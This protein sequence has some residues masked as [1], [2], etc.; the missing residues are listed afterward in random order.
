[1]AVGNV[2]SGLDISSLVQQLVSAE[3]APATARL[4]RDG[5]R[6][7]AEISA[8]GTLRSSFSNL[9]TALASVASAQT[10]PARK[11]IVPEGAG[12]SATSTAAASPARHQIEVRALATAHKLSSTAF[13]NADATVG[14]G[15]LTIT[16][17]T[18]T[19]TVD[20]SA[21]GNSLSALRDA[22]N[23]KAAGKGVA[24]TI[25]TADDGAHLM[26]T[27]LDTGTAH[28]I[29]VAA[30]GGDGGLA[31]FVYD[32]D[33]TRAMNQVAA[34]NDAVVAIDGMTRTSSSN[35]L[36]NA[37]SGVSL[38][39]TKAEPGT[40]RDLR[41]EADTGAQRNAVN[42]LVN[43]FNAAVGSLATATAYNTST[44]VAAALNGDAMAR[45]AGRDLR[46]LVSSNV[47]DLKA[48]GITIN[49]DGTLKFDGAAFDT[50]I[51]KDPALA[52]RLF[53]DGT[54][55][56]AS[57]LRGT[58]GAL[59][60]NGGS[61]TTR[62]EGLDRRNRALTE[63]RSDLDARMKSVESRYRAQFIGLDSLMTRL[64]SSMNFLSQ[65]LGL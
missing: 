52:S 31:A 34:P 10:S 25:V 1:M 26:L 15:Q 22:I 40:T 20:M 7:Q 46:Q 49:K 51:A 29:E 58:L 14:T 21:P 37:I 19:I 5:R 3:R 23:T 56:L 8:V 24:A 42:G 43:A 12:F 65:Q 35:T 50:A 63:A 16:S 18:T 11:V 60:D 36:A 27:A 53:G 4:D 32:P 9:R 28:A 17:G 30:S 48:A 55:T 13:A 62:S 59:L 41:I 61:L 47:A 57:R 45:G 64:Q 2:G 54:D 38:T 33:G 6:I 39:L 44:G